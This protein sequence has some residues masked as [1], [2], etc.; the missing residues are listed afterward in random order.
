M[1][2]VKLTFILSLF[3]ANVAWGQNDYIVKTA[4]QK[5]TATT[6]EERFIENNFP[7]YSLC[8]WVPGMK[9]MFILE[10]KFGFIPTFCSY[11]T[12]KEVDNNV[13]HYKIVTFE[14]VEEKEVDRQGRSFLSTRFVFDVEGKRYY[15][16]VK[17]QR[18]NE[19]CLK[20]PRAHIKG[21]VYLG[22]IDKA[23]Q[24]LIGRT[25]YT[26]TS[27]FRVDDSNSANGFREVTV[28]INLAV[29]ITAIGVGSREAPVKIVFDDN[30]GRS[31]YA[32][33]TLSTTNTGYVKSDF[34]GEQ[35][36][37]YFPNV[38]SFIDSHEKTVGEIKENYLGKAVYPIN[39][40][41]ATVGGRSTV[42][43]RY[44]P[45][46]IVEMEIGSDKDKTMLKLQDNSGQIYVVPVRLKYDVV[47]KN[48][49]YIN[50]IFAYGN[51]K[52]DYP[53]ISAKNWELI[54]NGEIALGMTKD[55][56]RLS[57]GNAAQI[58]KSMNSRYETW[59][60]NGKVLEFEDGKLIR[61]R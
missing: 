46:K 33:I 25:V 1:K 7:F 48:E 4:P 19:I 54:V 57:L 22:D 45:L 16:E 14:G 60:Y 51:L 43:F 53:Y 61:F 41:D 21:L 39:N 13:F 52:A 24:L 58:Q 18:L 6:A 29:R 35:R 56:C 49:D 23:R 38:F 20:T 11:E 17:S 15:H 26:K 59:Y 27:A 8:N 42:L 44:T 34:Q 40:M 55:E 47:I 3:I 9:F 31:Y 10:G 50:D 5:S 32:E 28:P 36:F 37:K 12:E 2:I 30:T